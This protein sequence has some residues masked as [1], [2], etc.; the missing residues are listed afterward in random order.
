MARTAEKLSALVVKRL[1]TTPGMHAV[2]VYRTRFFGHKFELGSML[3]T[4]LLPGESCL[5]RT[6]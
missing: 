6:A 1:S 3:H 4:G 2:G 5:A